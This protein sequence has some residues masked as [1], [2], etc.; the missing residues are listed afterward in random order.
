MPSPPR[1]REIELS[2]C[3]NKL[4]IRDRSSAAMPMPW[5]RTRINT[6]SSRGSTE[7]QIWLGFSVYFAAFDKQVADHLREPHHVAVDDDLP[8]RPREHQLVAPCIDRRLHLFDRPVDNF[9][10]VDRL[11]IEM[12]L[13]GDDPRHVQQV[14]DQPH[15]VNDLPLHHPRRF[16]NFRLRRPRHLQ[17]L[18]AVADRRQ[19]IP[20]L[21][22]QHRQEFVLLLVGKLQLLDL[23]LVRHVAR[24]L[25]E[26]SQRALAVVQ[27]RDDH[28]GPELRAVLANAPAFVFDAAFA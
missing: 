24:D 18:D 1:N 6:S 12:N 2:A 13:A 27:G 15:Q 25:G 14:V 3:S 17:Q 16:V 26:S 4:K 8:C 5:S 22:G 20:Q 21:V 23:P 9:A 7:S 28:V 10:H 19:R 11:F